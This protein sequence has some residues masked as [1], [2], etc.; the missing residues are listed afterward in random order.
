[1]RDYNKVN[2]VQK[3]LMVVSAFGE[4]K[5]FRQKKKIE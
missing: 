2:L 3:E 5:N 1:M 4:R